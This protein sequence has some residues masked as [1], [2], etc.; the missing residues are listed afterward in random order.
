MHNPRRVWV[1]SQE[2]AIDCP[3]K[4]LAL[5]VER[6]GVDIKIVNRKYRKEIENIQKETEQE[7]QQ[8]EDEK[9]LDDASIRK[10]IDDLKLPG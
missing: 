3:G 5:I 8:A 6:V 1:K 7:R 10:F 4:E 9:S 2:M